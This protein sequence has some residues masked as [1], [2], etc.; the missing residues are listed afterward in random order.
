MQRCVSRS[1]AAPVFLAFSHLRLGR[2]AEARRCMNKALATE[3]EA[4]FSWEVVEV[5]LL[6]PVVADLQ[7]EMGAPNK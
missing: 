6:R 5:E 3:A 4:Q 7:K 2:E 1:S